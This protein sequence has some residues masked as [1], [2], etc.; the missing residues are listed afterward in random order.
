MAELI[1][2]RIP[3]SGS[4]ETVEINE[5]LV[6][7]GAVVAEGDLLA[8]VSTDKADT[9]LESTANGK[10]A[11]IL[12]EPGAEVAVGTVVVLLVDEGASD[13]D[14]A[15]ARG[16]LLPDELMTDS[17]SGTTE[18]SPP[19]RRSRRATPTFPMS[20]ASSSS[21]GRRRHGPWSPPARCPR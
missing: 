17:P 18:P 8:E 14:V 10:V 13:D 21:A 5:W 3:H 11:K 2:V 16:R 6:A 7:E 4:V 20:S 9:E 15:A 19:I 12:F 1:E